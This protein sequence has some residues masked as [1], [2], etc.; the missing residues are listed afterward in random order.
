MAPCTPA[1]LQ[2]AIGFIVSLDY[3]LTG[4]GEGWAGLWPCTCTKMHSPIDGK[5]LRPER[6]ASM[7]LPP[8][9]SEAPNHLA[10]AVAM[11]AFCVC[12]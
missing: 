2:Q 12:K 6:F 1:L 8:L 5:M 7:S 3:L 10:K 11:L 4:H 9:L